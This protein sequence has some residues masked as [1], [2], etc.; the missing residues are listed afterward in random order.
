MQLSEDRAN[1]TAE[2]IK[3]RLG[4]KANGIKFETEGMGSDWDGF[5]EALSKSKI[6][7]KRQIEKQIMN[8]EDP[9]A[10]LNQLRGKYSQL[11]EI[12]NGLR[13]TEVF[14]K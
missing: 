9:T 2:Y 3:E 8:S 10:T 6:S 7:D 13:R 11:D 4:K 14:V 12:L 5:Y 1:A